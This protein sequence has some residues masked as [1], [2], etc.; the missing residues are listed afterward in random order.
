[1]LVELGLVEQR[2]KAVHEQVTLPIT[3]EA[4]NPRDDGAD[5]FT[6]P[7]GRTRRMLNVVDEYTQECLAID[8]ARSIDTEVS[9]C[10]LMSDIQH[11]HHWITRNDH[12]TQDEERGDDCLL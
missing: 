2:L 11:E 1:M 5:E 7:S 10:N 4:R 3:W 12:R 6:T 8:V 9:A